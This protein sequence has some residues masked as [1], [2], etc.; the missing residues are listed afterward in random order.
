MFTQSHMRLTQLLIPKITV[1]DKFFQSLSLLHLLILYD[2]EEKY[3]LGKVQ[4][5]HQ[6]VP[7]RC[8]LRHPRE[9]LEDS[10]EH[11]EGCARATFLIGARTLYVWLKFFIDLRSI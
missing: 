3:T 11:Y 4:H 9:D 1:Y 10:H 2:H 5:T 8:K 6:Q 7:V